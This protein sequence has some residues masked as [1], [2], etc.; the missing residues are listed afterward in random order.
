VVWSVVCGLA[1]AVFMPPAWLR[2][3]GLGIGKAPQATLMSPGPDQGLP[4]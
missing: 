1:V 4:R 2:A 3:I